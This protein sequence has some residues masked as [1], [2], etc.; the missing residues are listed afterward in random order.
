MSKVDVTELVDFGLNDGEYLPIIKCACGAKFDLWEF[1][2]SV[3]PDAA[4]ACPWCGRRF[5]FSVYIKVFEVED[6][7]A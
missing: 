7:Q 2:I 1:S 4:K 6:E 3:Y 5:Y